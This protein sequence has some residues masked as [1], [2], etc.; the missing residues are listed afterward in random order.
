MFQ[1]LRV[2]APFYILY[3]S[4][5][6]L[7]IGEVANV[8]VPVPQYG[9]T[10]QNGILTQPKSTV[11]IKVSVNGEDVMLKA[12]PSELSIADFGSSGMVVSESKDSIQSE[13]DAFQ[14]TSLRAL[15][16]TDKHKEIVSACD[17]MKRQLNPQIAKEAEQ[18]QRIDNLE[19]KL[20][21]IEQMLTKVLERNQKSKED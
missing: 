13:I 20:T 3:K 19:G 8:G 9:S 14:N 7:S 1:N 18:I 4:E 11:D 12:L 6:K 2:G 16:E 17:R 5:L 10:Y 21:N 15:G